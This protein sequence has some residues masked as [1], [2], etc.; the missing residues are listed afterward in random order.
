MVIGDTFKAPQYWTPQTVVHQGSVGYDGQ[1]YY[2][3]AHDPFILEHAHDHIDAPAYRYQRIMYPLA[4]WLLSLGRPKWIPYAMVAINFLSIL[5][6]TWTI[7][8]I[9]RRH[10]RSPWYAL[11]YAGFPGFLFSLLRSLPE[12]MAMALVV[13]AVYFHIKGNIRAQALSLGLAALTQETTLLVAMGFLIA[14]IY[15]KDLRSCLYLLFP[16][17]VYGLWRLYLYGQFQTVSFLAGIGNFGP[18]FLGILEKWMSLGRAGL[19]CAA[20]TELLFLLMVSAITLL[21]LY[22]AITHS[23]PLTLS[24]SGYALMTVCFSQFI[25]V[26]PWSYARATLGLL[27]FNF[28]IF[29]KDR[30][31]LNLAPMSL[32]PVILLLSLVS[33]GLF[34]PLLYFSSNS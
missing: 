29:A 20:T 32:L 8:L 30:T 16:P 15:E 12:P 6:G 13:V 3:I 22:D 10:R 31:V 28:L 11:F 18:P 4:A 2:Y 23:G 17:L 25:W 14:S 26:E 1:F 24:F 19:T 21:A 33:M 27:V 9:L 34:A 7:L 5:T